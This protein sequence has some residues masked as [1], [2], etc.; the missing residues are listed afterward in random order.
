MKS[1][2]LRTPVNWNR[3]NDLI[4]ELNVLVNY[5]VGEV[6]KIENGG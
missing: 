1:V 4:K 3:N 6:L 5:L 2:E